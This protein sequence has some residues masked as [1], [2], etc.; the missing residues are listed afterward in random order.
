[1]P[2][3]NNPQTEL[4]N[5][6]SSAQSVLLLLP[7]EP[8][9]DS[10]NAALTLY[11]ALSPD[12]QILLG[13]STD[14]K[15]K[16]PDLTGVEAAK[17]H[18]GNQTLVVSFDYQEDAVENVSYDI[19]DATKKFNLRI[20]PRPNQAPLDVSKVSYSYTGAQADLVIT[21][22]INSLEELGSL[23]SEEKSF[24]DT[25]IIANLVASPR[26]STFA[27]LNLNFPSL[28]EAMALLIKELG[29]QLS[30]QVATNMF[31]TLTKSTNNFQ[32][33][34]VNADTFELAAFLLRSGA[35]KSAV[36]RPFP[37]PFPFVP[38]VDD[39]PDLATMLP[40]K[41]Q[42]PATNYQQGVPADWSGPKIYR[43]G[44]PLK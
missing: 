9:L 44:S 10:T 33:S 1:M 31:Q 36:A 18:I 29:L 12:K 35:Q 19:D 16:Y 8:D 42:L 13:C 24:M 5:K 25:A 3:V 39:V 41:T 27:T 21:F 14:L 6:L 40:T 26:P 20:Q 15:A 17:N 32:A 37:S 2:E 11:Q 30:P 38:P 23:Y 4:K 7:P 28:A 22:G 34:M 43:G